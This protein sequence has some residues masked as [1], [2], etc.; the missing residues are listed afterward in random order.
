M[1]REFESRTHCHHDLLIFQQLLFDID[2]FDSWT[3]FHF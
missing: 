1:S 3:C 2:T